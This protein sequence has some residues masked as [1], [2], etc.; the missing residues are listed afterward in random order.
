[1]QKRT[2]ILAVVAVLLLAV[3]LLILQRPGERSNA[4]D[5][6]NLFVTVDSAAV[7]RIEISNP[8]SAVLLEKRGGEW[9]L[10][11]P[12]AFRADQASI[13][14]LLHT[15]GSMNVKGVVSN[16]PEKRSVFQVDSAGT[17]VRLSSGT[18]EQAAIVVGKL[19]SSYS[20]SY[21]RKASSDDVVLVERISIGQFNKPLREWRDRTIFAQ[22]QS[23]IT[24]IGFQYGDTTFTISRRDS[25]W[26]VDGRPARAEAV[27]G[28]MNALGSLQAD[29]FIDGGVTPAP[30]M[31]AQISIGRTQLRFAIQKATGKYIVQSSTSAQRYVLEPWRA[32]QVLLRKKDLLEASK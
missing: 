26:T 12:I 1:M 29:D 10:A 14:A 19:S 2:L 16:R 15:I 13:A 6:A 18:T 28:L 23:M 32:N 20:E 30:R 3:T 24:D 25:V 17:L 9:F 8:T 22:P 27:E 11:Q 21:V 7:D 5:V 4:S 31:T